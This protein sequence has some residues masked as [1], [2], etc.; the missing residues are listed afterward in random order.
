MA[1]IIFKRCP[2]VMLEKRSI[3]I[4]LAN[5]KIKKTKFFIDYIISGAFFQ[6]NCSL[7]HIIR[8]F[9]SIFVYLR[10]K[11]LSFIYKVQQVFLYAFA[12][13]FPDSRDFS[14]QALS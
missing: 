9:Q 6:G 10:L 11:F 14:L 7:L 13:L 8:I 12:S 2:S 1:I 5:Y 4:Y 3:L